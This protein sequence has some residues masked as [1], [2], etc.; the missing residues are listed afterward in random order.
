M[1]GEGMKSLEICSKLNKISKKLA[2]A[3]L[4]KSSITGFADILGD[5]GNQLLDFHPDLSKISNQFNERNCTQNYF[6]P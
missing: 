1:L 3:N 2:V 4:S 6:K 5:G